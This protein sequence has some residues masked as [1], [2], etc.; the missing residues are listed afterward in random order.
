[1]L[2]RPSKVRALPP[3]PHLCPKSKVQRPKSNV[4]VDNRLW[5]LDLSL[6]T[7]FVDPELEWQSS[8]LLIRKVRVQ[9][10]SGQPVCLQIPD[11]KFQIP[12]S[13]VRSQTEDQRWTLGIRPVSLRD[14]V[15][16]NTSGFE[17]EV[18]GSIPSPAASFN[19]QTR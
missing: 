5:T 3:Q 12:K 15:T 11:S 10:P 13:E 1:M 4:S 9:A 7:W 8:G 18:E 6:W 2:I 19:K 16:G 17:L 14:G